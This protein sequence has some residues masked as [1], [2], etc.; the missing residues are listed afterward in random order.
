M[1]N[2]LIAI[3]PLVR[4]AEEG[5]PV[6]FFSDFFVPLMVALVLVAINGLFVAAE[7]ASATSLGKSH[8]TSPAAGGYGVNVGVD[9]VLSARG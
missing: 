6:S 4:L 7:F 9:A 8:G 3:P 5:E 2:F 1:I